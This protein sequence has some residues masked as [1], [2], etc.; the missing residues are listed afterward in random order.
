M[1]AFRSWL[2]WITHGRAALVGL[3]N[4]LQAKIDAEVLVEST[5]HAWT[6]QQIADLKAKLPEPVRQSPQVVQA[7]TWREFALMTDQGDHD[8]ADGR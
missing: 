3:R 4:E 6:M 1:K 8:D 2:T 7:K 5:H